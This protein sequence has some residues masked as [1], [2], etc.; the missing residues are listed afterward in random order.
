MAKGKNEATESTGADEN[1]V[2]AKVQDSDRV[3]TVSYD[4]GKTLQDSISMFGEDVVH[5]RFVAAAVIDLQSLIRRG[6]RPDKE[7]N[8]KTDE[9]IAAMAASWKPGV[10]Q[11]S[12]KSPQDK[13]KDA[14]SGLSDEQRKEL[15]AQLKADLAA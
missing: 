10:K 4:F 15:L 13:I 9:Q 5:S 14:F 8:T 2:S 1:S 11:I 7:G 3:V 6:I 12:R